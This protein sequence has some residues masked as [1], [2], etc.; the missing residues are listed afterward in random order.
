MLAD[1][2][3]AI[4]LDPDNAMMLQQMTSV[5]HEKHDYVEAIKLL[6]RAITLRLSWKKHG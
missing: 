6:R 1:F 4:E 2:D 5:C 3:R